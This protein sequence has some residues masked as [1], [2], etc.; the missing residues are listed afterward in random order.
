M[1]EMDKTWWGF[2]PLRY[3]LL[4]PIWG[5]GWAKFTSSVPQSFKTPFDG[6]RCAEGVLLGP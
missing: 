5:P 1:L 3:V 4:E 2:G 6:H